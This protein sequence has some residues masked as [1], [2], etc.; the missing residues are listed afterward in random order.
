M[1][2]NGSQLTSSSV[3]LSA[4]SPPKWPC[5]PSECGEYMLTRQTINHHFVWIMSSRCVEHYGGGVHSARMCTSCSNQNGTTLCKHTQQWTGHLFLSACPA[6]VI[7]K[8][9]VNNLWPCSP[10]LNK[11]LLVQALVQSENM[12]TGRV[13]QLLVLL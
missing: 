3:C 7:K 6:C 8:W 12:D 11:I 1:G 9:S 13:F 5:A 10:K 2:A 4:L